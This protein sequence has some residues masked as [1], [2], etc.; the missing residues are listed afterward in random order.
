MLSN[1]AMGWTGEGGEFADSNTVA[2]KYKK[3]MLTSFGDV[4]FFMCGSADRIFS[5]YLSPCPYYFKF[6]HFHLASS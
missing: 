2:G 4:L 1:G 5:D 6:S 3:P